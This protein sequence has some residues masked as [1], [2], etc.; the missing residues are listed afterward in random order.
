MEE[1]KKKDI[2]RGIRTFKDD[3]AL[4]KEKFGDVGAQKAE[5]KELDR[6]RKEVIGIQREARELIKEQST[7]KGEEIEKRSSE[8]LSA[9]PVD[10]ISQA[11]IVKDAALGKAWKDFSSRRRKWE[12]KGIKARDLRGINDGTQSDRRTK[13]IIFLTLIGLFLTGGLIIIGSYFIFAKIKTPIVK[14]PPIV[15]TQFNS[16]KISYVNITDNN[17]ELENILSVKQKLGVLTEIVP[18]KVVNAQNVPASIKQMFIDFDTSAPTSLISS[19]SGEYFIGSLPSKSKDNYILVLY[20]KNHA[21]AIVGTKAWEKLMF[22]DIKK[23]FPNS[24]KGDPS[25]GENIEFY[26][27]IVNNQNVRILE[28]KD[29]EILVIYG[30]VNS[31]ALIISTDDLTFINI[32]DRAK[33]SSTSK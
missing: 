27:S 12:E 7:L 25:A 24:Y 15:V 18:Y 6:Q 4:F 8:I 30:I 13:R 28:D 16:E 19:L 10:S 26:S 3:S 22:K 23:I 29:G 33:N 11:K 1:D 32:L 5:A 9:M 31:R 14:A 17:S 2:L 20:I 21:S